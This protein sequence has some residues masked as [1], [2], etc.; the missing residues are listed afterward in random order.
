M[1]VPSF[2]TDEYL[3]IALKVHAD[4]SGVEGGGHIF[5]MRFLSSPVVRGVCSAAMVSSS[6]LNVG[7]AGSIGGSGR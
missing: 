3:M 1:D 2:V 4:P 5:P 7:G 6:D